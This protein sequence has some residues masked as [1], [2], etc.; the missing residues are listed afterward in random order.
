MYHFYDEYIDYL[1]HRMIKVR[2]EL[3][4]CDSLIS[5][6]YHSIEHGMPIV[7]CEKMKGIYKRRRTCKEMIITLESMIDVV[8]KQKK[9]G[10]QRY[11]S[12]RSETQQRVGSMSGLKKFLLMDFSVNR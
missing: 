3:K 9:R 2:E 12:Y 8:K 5:E 1:N 6:F 4:F 11:Q 7:D 10:E